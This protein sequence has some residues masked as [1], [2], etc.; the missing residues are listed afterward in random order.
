M[1]SATPL[2][3]SQ[4]GLIIIRLLKKLGHGF[5]HQCRLGLARTP[6]FAFQC[7]LKLSSQFD[8]QHNQPQTKR[9]ILT[10]ENLNRKTLNVLPQPDMSVQ[11]RSRLPTA[12]GFVTTPQGVFSPEMIF[13]SS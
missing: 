5:T 7:R 9:G 2:A 1:G 6:R 11:G 4:Y 10:S 13:T 3:E 8:F 12:F